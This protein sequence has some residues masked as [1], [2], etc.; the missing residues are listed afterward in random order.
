MVH[1]TSPSQQGVHRLHQPDPSVVG[2]GMSDG[3]IG[4]AP[5]ALRGGNVPSVFSIAHWLRD[6]RLSFQAGA[7]TLAPAPW[8]DSQG[9]FPLLDDNGDV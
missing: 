6:R 1:P 3:S 2:I 7:V 5:R 9:T 4:R 8:D